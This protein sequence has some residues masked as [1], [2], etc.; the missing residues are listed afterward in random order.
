M[1][2]KNE[3]P[4]VYYLDPDYRLEPPKHGAYCIRCQRPIF[5]TTDAVLVS[6]V[7]DFNVVLGGMYLIG[8][9]CWKKIS[10]NK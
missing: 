9:D 1:K 6:Y 2:A 3:S 5:S 8:K 7:D 4:K 10:E